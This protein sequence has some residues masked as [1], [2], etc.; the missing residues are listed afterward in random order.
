MTSI[1]STQYS[2][3]SPRAM[4]DSKISQAVS[5]GTISTDDQS[6]FSTALDSIDSSL[7]AARTSGTRPSGDI[8]SKVDS[9]IDEQVKSGK[10]TDDQADE[11]KTLFAQGPGSADKASGTGDVGG[12]GGPRGPGGPGGPPPCGGA[13]SGEDEEEDDDETTTTEDATAQIDALM[14]F[15]EKLRET[16]SSGVYGDS[17]STTSSGSGN[18]GLVVNATA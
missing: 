11:L 9:L 2:H 18:S 13:S 8:K 14:A 4:M 12:M 10:L 1:S 7:E 5:A 15:L 3:F 17:G 16:L 6:A